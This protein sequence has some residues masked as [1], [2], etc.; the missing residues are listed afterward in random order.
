MLFFVCFTSLPVHT[1]TQQEYLLSILV[2]MGGVMVY[3]CVLGTVASIMAQMD[4]QTKYQ[5]QQVTKLE[6]FCR[7]YDL[8]IEIQQRVLEDSELFFTSHHR[9]TSYD[10]EELLKTM[11]YRLRVQVGRKGEMK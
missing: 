7:D 9:S 11:S 6:H 3:S 8:P 1:G 4:D 2:M 10:E 5:K